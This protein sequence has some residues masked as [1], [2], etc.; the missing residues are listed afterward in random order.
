[1]QEQVKKIGGFFIGLAVIIGIVFLLG[2]LLKG[3]LWLSAV[4]YTSLTYISAITFIFSL[5]I[6]VPLGF[7]KTTRGFSATGLLIASY[8]F[9]LS[10]W[11]WTFLLSYAFWGIIGVFIG[12]FLSGVGV[13][14]V[15]IFGMLVNGA[16]SLLGQL[17]FIIFVTWGCRFLSMYLYSLDYNDSHEEYIQTLDV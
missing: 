3:G 4:A 1:M 12:I 17:I 16:W 15:A 6:L 5:I 10:T 13:I 14:P 8:I 7:F 2:L 9:A 11:V